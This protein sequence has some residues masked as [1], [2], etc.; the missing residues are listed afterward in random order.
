MKT[1][2]AIVNDKVKEEQEQDNEAEQL[3][4]EGKK[5]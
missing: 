2:V 1:L 4:E 5:L 3:D